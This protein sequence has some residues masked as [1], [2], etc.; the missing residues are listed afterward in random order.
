MFLL[1]NN[2]CR[3]VMH[4]ISDKTNVCMC[5]LAAEKWNKFVR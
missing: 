5:D 2:K 1:M 4:T 3:L